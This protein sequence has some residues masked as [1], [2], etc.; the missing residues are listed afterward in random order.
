[1]TFDETVRFLLAGQEE[2]S[3][4]TP[5]IAKALTPDDI[6]TLFA[7][8]RD[9]FSARELAHLLHLVSE[10]YETDAYEADCDDKVCQVI[11][12]AAGGLTP[13]DI[14]REGGW[15]QWLVDDSLPRLVAAG[16]VRRLGTQ[17]V[18]ARCG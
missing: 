6:C 17:F 15:M 5:E 13:S 9:H 16:R 14:A 1:M 4:L 18:V 2:D 8:H 10:K 11:A 12:H 3:V 7:I